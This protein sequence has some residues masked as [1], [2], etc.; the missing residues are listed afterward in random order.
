[1]YVLQPKVDSRHYES[2]PIDV[3][4]NMTFDL[5][6]VVLNVDQIGILT[7]TDGTECHLPMLS[8]QV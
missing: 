8:D 2:L 6:C 3:S 4:R 1:M 7:V 5:F